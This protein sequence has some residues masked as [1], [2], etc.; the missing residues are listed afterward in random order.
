MIWQILGLFFFG[1]LIDVLAVFWQYYVAKS[2]PFIA[3][4]VGTTLTACGIFGYVNITAHHWMA[5]PYLMGIWCGAVLGILIK[6]R[7]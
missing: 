4:T 2:R 1:M 6:R 3:A 7:I 5:V